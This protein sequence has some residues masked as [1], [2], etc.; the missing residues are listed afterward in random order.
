MAPGRITPQREHDRISAL[1]AGLAATVIA[2]TFAAAFAP[3]ELESLSQY[4][5]WVYGPAAIAAW[6]LLS[7]I[8]YL[9]ISR[10]Q[11]Q[12]AYFEPHESYRCRDFAPAVSASCASVCANLEEKTRLAA[13]SAGLALTMS[14]WIAALSFM[15]SS[16]LDGLHQAPAWIYCLGSVILW[17][18]LS[19]GMYLVFRASRER[20]RW[21]DINRLTNETGLDPRPK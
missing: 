15:P 20:T 9:L 4:S 8:A 5:P 6:I 1:A 2:W 3:G 17:A 14:I 10:N 7:A 12:S 18:G 21:L 13:I 11:R 19:A 16:W